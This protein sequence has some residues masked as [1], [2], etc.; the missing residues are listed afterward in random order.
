MA[1]SI[2]LQMDENDFNRLYSSS[3]NWAGEDWATQDGRFEPLPDY[4]KF[5]R[6][7]W[8]ENYVDLLVARSYLT[9]A[10]F[11]SSTHHDG[12]EDFLT[13]VLLTD[14]GGKL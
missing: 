7:Y 11:E 4:R 2:N 14:F 10:G 6:A 5:I 3:M 8:F 13:H 1:T 9:A 12:A